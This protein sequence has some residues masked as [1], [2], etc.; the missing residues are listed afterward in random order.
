MRWRA[1]RR[2]ILRLLATMWLI[3]TIAFFCAYRLP[4]DPAR[5][6]LGQK[7]TAESLEDFRRK[8]G[9]DQPAA[10]QYFRFVKRVLRL[11]LGDSLVQRRPVVKLIA[12]RGGQTATLVGVSLGVLALC[13]L[14]VPI[15]IRL[16]RWPVFQVLYS[17]GWTAL[18][19]AP[20]YVL[21]IV[22]LLCF[23]A[24][25]GWIPV[26]FDPGRPAAWLLPAVVLA[27]YP[28]A[29]T[30]RLLNDQIEQT[31]QAPYV[32]AARAYGYTEQGILLRF[33]LPNAITPALAAFANG[34][35]FFVTGTFFVE[36]VFGIGGLGTLAYEAVR[37]KDVPVLVG[38]SIVFAG[39]ICAISTGLQALLFALDPRSEGHRE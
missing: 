3:V 7:A 5:M 10:V 8:T 22:A 30:V 13:G 19:I 6:I 25:L 36:V 29:I 12:E 18:A 16:A 26:T 33:A 27:A 38:L 32:T 35:A 9:L 1:L 21:S 28:A 11:D 24:W 2:T 39:A 17:S 37:N 4:G 23:A 34:M 15:A 31:L 14:A 20:P